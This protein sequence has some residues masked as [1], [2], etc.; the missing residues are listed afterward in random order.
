MPDE[1]DEKYQRLREAGKNARWLGI[2]DVQLYVRRNA[3]VRFIAIRVLRPFYL[4]FILLLATIAVPAFLFGTT[5]EFDASNT[6]DPSYWD[7]LAI[8]IESDWNIDPVWGL[9]V[10]LAIVTTLAT[11][12][13]GILIGRYYYNKSVEENNN[14][15]TKE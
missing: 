6:T 13:S 1:L 7:R 2:D 10:L 12:I 4:N 9:P 11:I 3:T 8:W 15:A 14:Q 5:Y